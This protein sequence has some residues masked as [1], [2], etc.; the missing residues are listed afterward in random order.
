MH[1]IVIA[2]V[3]QCLIAKDFGLWQNSFAK[4]PGKIL[5]QGLDAK[6]E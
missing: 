3:T 5:F 6:T 4:E 1:K 2:L